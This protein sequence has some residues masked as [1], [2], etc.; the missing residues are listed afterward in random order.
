LRQAEKRTNLSAPVVST[1][2]TA[3]P[4]NHC[5]AP[6]GLDLPRE[7]PPAF[8]MGPEM[9]S[10]INRKVKRW[11]IRQYKKRPLVLLSDTTLRDGAQMPGL[12]LMVEGR[13]RI[14]AALARAGVHSI[15]AGFPA[16]GA[17]EV[18]AVRQVVRA[19]N[20]PIFSVLARALPGDVDLA[21]DA[22]QDVS[23]LKK[24]VT[25]FIG[26]SPLH[27]R[28][29][30]RMDRP[31][32]IDAVVRAVEHAQSAFEL[33]SLGAEDASR[34]EPEFLHRVYAE[35]IAAGATSIGFTD[36]VGILTPD[37]AADAVKRIQDQVTNIDDAMLAV[38]FHNDLGLATANALA[39]IQAG[40]NIV[41]GTVNGIGER[42]GNLAIEEVVL[43]M[44]L[45]PDQYGKEITARPE[46]LHGLSRVVAEVTGVEPAANKPIVGR[47]IF[48]TET[49]IHQDASN[50]PRSTSGWSSP[51][52]RATA[53]RRTRRRRSRASS[54]GFAPSSPGTSTCR[55]RTAAM[56]R[57]GS[58]VTRQPR[59]AGSREPNGARAEAGAS[60]GPCRSVNEQKRCSRARTPV[61]K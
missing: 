40:A 12:R 42:A 11:A 13:V 32:V 44:T 34:T 8:R 45:H 50:P 4:A 41:Q 6:F 60:A 19:V 35:A 47:N 43:A 18:D 30:L 33:I 38:H 24:A 46:A 56:A 48:R 27:R 29:K 22:L 55:G 53:S 37:R 5:P 14:A 1:A 17:A 10:A 61:R 20:G 3:P 23:P 9:F 21:A 26:T 28:D 58:I 52:S 54:S 7:P 49:G 51:T 59:T 16:A 25:L 39:C 2:V 57:P 36:T 31:G 15:D